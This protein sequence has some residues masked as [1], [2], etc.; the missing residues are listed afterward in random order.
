MAAVIDVRVAPNGRMVLPRSAREALGVKGAG[1]VLLSVEGGE[2][3]L[4]SMAQAVARAQELY[5]THASA[6]GSSEA[7]LAERRREAAQ[8]RA[9]EA[10]D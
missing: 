6:D 1:V 9:A 2:V 10:E 7:F 8:D 4:T 5:R 3:K